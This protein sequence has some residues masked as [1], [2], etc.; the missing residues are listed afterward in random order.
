[1]IS[2]AGVLRP[3]LVAALVTLAGVR[4]LGALEIRGASHFVRAPW[5]VDLLSYSTNVWEGNPEYYFTLEL[6]SDAG[7]SLAGLTIQQVRG[8]DRQFGFNVAATRAF[9]GRPRREGRPVPTQV[10]FDPLERQFSVVFPEPVVPGTTVTVVI[11]PW[12]NPSQADTYLF[13]VTALPAGADPVA[14]PVGFG[15]LRIYQPTWG[16]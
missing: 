5:K 12:R 13:Q 10:R 9:V 16:F 14:S 8:V 7:A 11:R 4:P 2:L 6:A 1:M 15:T 3:V